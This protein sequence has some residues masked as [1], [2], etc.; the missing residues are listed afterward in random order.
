MQKYGWLSTPLVLYS[1][2]SG[3]TGIR[4]Q[5]AIVPKDITAYADSKKITRVLAQAEEWRN[6]GIIVKNGM[7]YKIEA[8]GKWYGG[9]TMN[10]T[11]PD[12]FG[13][14]H[15]LAWDNNFKVIQ[16]YSW[17]ALI[18]KIGEAGNPFYIGEQYDFTAEQEGILYFRM[19]DGE[20]WC[21]DNQGVVTVETKLISAAKRQNELPA[22]QIAGR[23]EPANSGTLSTIRGKSWAVVIGI[24]RYQYQGSNGLSEL[25]FADDDAKAFAQSLRNLGWSE[26]HIKLI[27]N[28]KATKRNIEICLES[29]LSKAGNNDQVVIFWAGHGY[30]DPADPE[31][32]Y[33]ATY[34]TDISIPATG[35]R[36]D[37]VRTSLEEIGSK[38]VILLADTCH[39]G[40]LITR[41]GRG[42]SIVPQI[43]KMQRDRKVPKGW[44]F[45]VGADSDRQAIEHTSWTNGAFTHT[46]INGLNGAADG[47]QSAG[48][49]DGVVNM[50]ELKAYVTTVMPDETQKVI[51]VAKHPVITT[52]TGDPEIWNLTLQIDN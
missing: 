49:K 10:W 4:Y 38:N 39:A 14:T 37:R 11:G 13:A 23:D 50:G 33:L 19:N 34:D 5:D 31:K 7:R 41:G 17:T 45:M 30:P 25:I 28:E 26:A 47:F 29:W 9:G 52:S 16:G 20:G 32:V 51:G 1:L 22:A 27:T 3:C 6:S 12:G 18:A 40:K 46:L 35:Y 24:S 21:G 43:E 8:N 42:I 48:V 36:M 2:L 15:A 44:I